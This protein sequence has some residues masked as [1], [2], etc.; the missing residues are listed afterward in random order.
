MALRGESFTH[1]DHTRGRAASCTL[2]PMA[3]GEQFL[4]EQEKRDLG[5]GTVLSSRP[6]LRL[7]NRDG[8]FNV[9]RRTTRWWRRVNSYIGLLT[10]PWKWFFA[11]LAL[12]YLVMNLIFAALY[13][14]CGPGALVGA[15][16]GSF[17]SAFFFSVETFATIGYGN[18]APATLAANIVVTVESLVGLISFALA[19]GIIFARFARPTA[20]I[21]YS[22]HAVIA[23]Y[24]N[25]TAFMFRI[26]NG[27][28]NELINLGARLLL[29]RF[30]DIDGRRQRR[31]HYLTLERDN[32]AF[33]PL[34]WTIVHPIDE[35]SPLWGW[36]QQRLLES[37]AEFL[38]LLTGTD[39]TFAQDV[40]SR[41]SYHAAEVLWNMR[42][43]PLLPGDGG[44][45]TVDM[46]QFHKVLQ[47]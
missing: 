6:G 1:P 33:F 21:V 5:F 8:S 38:I 28:E 19:T 7:L 26:I 23:P 34:N 39:E 41:S 42:F 15:T 31:Y 44:P 37:N 10:T 20:N 18:I 43:A 16:D 14:A 47:A 11:Y 3:R 12:G 35:D 9:R 2:T 32:V 27:R 13:K 22:N 25:I 29:T 45:A 17:L 40:H 4:T 30:E 24:R 36:D 46:R